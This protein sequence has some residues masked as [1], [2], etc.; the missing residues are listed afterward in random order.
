MDISSLSLVFFIII[1]LIYYLS[2]IGKP[3]LTVED[4]IKPNYLELY[5]SSAM[6]PLI[7]YLIVI[8][9]VEYLIGLGTMMSK[10]GNPGQ[11]ASAAFMSVVIPWIFIFGVIVVIILVW[12]GFKGTFSNVIG[13]AV[14][15]S[16]ATK[17]FTKLL[18]SIERSE[19]MINEITPANF[20]IMWNTLKPLMQTNAFENMEYKKELLDI[21]TKRD[22]IG[23]VVWYIYGAIL[24]SSVVTYNLATSNCQQSPEQIKAQHDA[25]LK[26]QEDAEIAKEQN[27]TEYTM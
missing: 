27:S 1:T 9:V 6:P 23:E 14:V 17:L 4:V 26:E 11:A 22:N 13:Y 7:L 3:Y 2:P 8:L 24:V 10:C 16:S 18:T 15:V 21:V 12:P 20:E 19:L 25:Y 5:N